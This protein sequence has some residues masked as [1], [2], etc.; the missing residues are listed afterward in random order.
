[1]AI[2]LR[3]LSYNP[4]ST[5]SATPSIGFPS[6]KNVGVPTTKHKTFCYNA[7]SLDRFRKLILTNWKSWYT[8]AEVKGHDIS[9][10]DII[11]V[12]G[13]DPTSDSSPQR[14]GESPMLEPPYN[15]CRGYRVYRRLEVLESEIARRPE[16]P[17]RDDGIMLA[18][19][20]AVVEGARA[21]PLNGSNKHN[22]DRASSVTAVANFPKVL[23]GFSLHFDI[24]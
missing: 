14:S 4:S 10:E 8:Y 24:N 17:E 16:G 15:Q 6:T 2:G 9:A 20:S 21:V 12:T 22:G 3:I 23:F 1:M 11:L 7:Q 18:D 5:A 19:N 13:C